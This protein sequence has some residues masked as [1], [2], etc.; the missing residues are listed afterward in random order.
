MVEVPIEVC[1][2]RLLQRCE[3]L[4]LYLLQQVEAHKQI[5]LV[6][7]P[8]ASAYSLATIFTVSAHLLHHAPVECS[9]IRQPLGQQV[10][11][12]VVVYIGEVA[13]QAQEPLLQLAVVVGTEVAEEPLYHGPLLVCE[14]GDIVQ[15]VYVPQ[16]GEHAV[17]VGHVLVDVV[18]VTEQQ[19]APAVEL[20]QRLRGARLPTE[21]LVQLAHKLDGVGHL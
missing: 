18:E 11:V 7:E 5:V 14:V 21:R 10:L 2:A 4:L 16:V 8:R 17:R 6:R 9:L 13:P 15:L 1:L 3:Q 19:L 12:E 20:V